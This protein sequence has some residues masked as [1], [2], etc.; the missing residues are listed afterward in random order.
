[1][2]CFNSMFYLYLSLSIIYQAILVCYVP[3]SGSESRMLRMEAILSAVAGLTVSW[4]S[5]FSREPSSFT[6]RSITTANPKEIE[7]GQAT[8]QMV[9]MLVLLHQVHRISFELMYA[10]PYRLD[11][12]TWQPM[13][14][15]SQF[16]TRLS[17][18]LLQQL[19]GNRYSTSFHISVFILPASLL[20]SF[21]SP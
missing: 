14:A 9:K 2:V 17:Y 16:G 4:S 10:R 19:I 11:D 18:R 13:R 21:L 1:M 15:W 7:T 8:Q 3:D 12:P 6:S 20:D 5:I